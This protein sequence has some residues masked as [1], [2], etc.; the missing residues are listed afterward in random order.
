MIGLSLCVIL[1]APSL[2][3]ADQVNFDNVVAPADF[4]QVPS[5]NPFVAPG[6]TF[7]NG[8]VLND[9]H[10]GSA[11]TTSPNLYATTDFHPLGDLTLLPGFIV[12][13]FTSGTGSGLSLDVIN[14]FGAADFTLTA[15][16]AAN[17]IL[18]VTSIFLNDF[19]FPGSVGSLSLGVSGIDH[20]TVTTDQAGGFIDFAID[21]VNFTTTGTTPTPEPGSLAMLGAGL[22]GLLGYKRSRKQA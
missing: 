6:I 21:S 14:G 9:T 3:R 7:T 17:N 22:L 8:V 1:A 10:F 19:T 2:M 16:D 13:T 5:Y 12:G 20:F 4:V 11:S 15:Y 18:G